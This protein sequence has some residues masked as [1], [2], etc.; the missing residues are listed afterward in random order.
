LGEGAA[1]I[2]LCF[3]LVALFLSHFFPVQLFP[4][5]PPIS[6]ANSARTAWVAKSVFANIQVFS[7]KLMP[8]FAMSFRGICISKQK[9][10]FLFNWTQVLEIYAR[11]ISA[12][13]VKNKAIR[14]FTNI[15]LVRPSVR[16]VAGTVED[17]RPWPARILSVLLGKRLN[18]V[19]KFCTHAND[20]SSFG[21]MAQA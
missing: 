3:A 14:N 6:Y 9:V 2:F 16:S 19:G 1:V 5:V 18:S 4:S 20:H 13:V 11:F 10:G 21:R 12:N 7:R 17:E 8:I 15:F